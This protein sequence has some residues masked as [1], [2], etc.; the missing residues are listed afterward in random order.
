VNIQGAL[1][2]LVAVACIL[3]V[4]VAS[5]SLDAVETDP[6][7]V[8]DTS[9]IPTQDNQPQA[10]GDGGGGSSN[11]ADLQPD[12]SG[13]T[14]AG[15]E[16][17][18][19][20]PQESQGGGGGGGSQSLTVTFWDRLWYT[21]MQNLVYIVGG[22]GALVAGG[23][24]YVVYKRRFAGGPG[25]GEGEIYYDVDTSNEIYEAWWEMVEMSGVKD[26]TTKTPQEFAEAAIDEGYD[27]D[28]VS[29]L[30]QLFERIHYGGEEVTSE[31]ERRA[32]EAIERIKSKGRE[33][34]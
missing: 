5:T 14:N 18:Q 20:T 25:P 9:F 29:E 16:E 32:R 3:A 12:D 11:N 10:D 21:I 33:A 19:G 31:E 26:P 8:M 2:T 6:S 27:P 7:D 34:V 28:A 30:T 22:I 23:I 17:T 13:E 15:T 1:T 24:G 4:G